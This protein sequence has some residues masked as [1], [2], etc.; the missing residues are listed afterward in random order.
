MNSDDGEAS[1]HSGDGEEDDGVAFG[2]GED[3][4][5][6]DEGLFNPAMLSSYDPYSGVEVSFFNS[7]VLT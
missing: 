2:G 7:F 5:E 4:V 3:D 1:Y 6:G